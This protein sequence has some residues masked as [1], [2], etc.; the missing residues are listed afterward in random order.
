MTTKKRKDSKG[1][2]LRKGEY[3]RSNGTY[4]YVHRDATGKQHTVYA[5]TLKKLRE[6]E[7]EVNHDVLDGIKLNGKRLR[8]NDV[9]LI[10][11]S[12][13]ERDVD[14]GILRDN[15]FANYCYMFEQFVMPTLG[16]M[17]LADVTAARIEAFYKTL[18]TERRLKLNTVNTVHL[19]LKQV[20]ELAVQSDYIRKNPTANTMRKISA[21]YAKKQEGLSSAERALTKEQ[22]QLFLDYLARD[23]ISR[24]WYPIFAIMLKTGM[25]V[26]EI[27]GLRWC[28]VN[29]DEGFISVNHGL[30]HNSKGKQNGQPYAIN[31]TKTPAGKR[32]IPIYDEVQELFKEEWARQKADGIKCRISV[33]GYTDFV[34]LNKEGH[35]LNQSTLNKALRRIIRDCNFEVMKDVKDLDAAVVLPQ[36]STHWLRHTFATRLIESGVNVKAA[37]KLLGHADV[38]TTLN[39]YTDAQDDFVREELGKYVMTSSYQNR[40]NDL[41]TK[42][43]HS[44]EVRVA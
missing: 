35:C 34:F 20:F 5:P 4:R 33:D 26:G 10:W 32:V 8:I 42:L 39:I 41:P 17:R 30:V 13:R 27:T 14:A 3:E 44:C 7:D 25:R 11:K 23:E 40:T 37:Q 28:D 36:F 1:R 29:L 38:S 43:E 2:V 15:T 6:K 9:Y 18:I 22:Q 19:P 31:D 12:T 16:K 24:R 21:A